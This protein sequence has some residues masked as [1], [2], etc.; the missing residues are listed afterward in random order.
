[1]KNL[2]SCILVV[3]LVQACCLLGATADEI[4]DVL[5][6][7]TRAEAEGLPMQES[8][9]VVEEPGQHRPEPEPAM[10]AGEYRPLMLL[11]RDELEM[12]VMGARAEVERLKGI[13]RRILVANRR[14]KEAMHYNIG[15]VLRSV[16]QY[17]KAEQAFMEALALNPRDPAVHFN[18][19]I[20]YDE[21]LK[22]P[23]KAKKHYQVFLNLAPDDEDAGRVY[24]WLTALE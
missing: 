7:E 4:D 6:L 18:L 22:R 8:E 23:D 1:M 14:E 3:V 9:D 10:D 11:T 19:G 15:C 21:D 5:G 20:L 2:S 17:R 12:E 16:G 24:Q 13:V